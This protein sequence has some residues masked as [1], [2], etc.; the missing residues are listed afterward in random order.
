M[1]NLKKNLNLL[2]FLQKKVANLKT[3]ADLDVLMKDAQLKAWIKKDL[4]PRLLFFISCC[5]FKITSYKGIEI[6]SDKEYYGTILCNE[7]LFEATDISKKEVFLDAKNQKYKHYLHNIR[8][9]NNLSFTL[10]TLDQLVSQPIQ[11]PKAT[12]KVQIGILDQFGQPN[13]NCI[14]KNY[15]GQPYK[16]NED[17]GEL[18]AATAI[19]GDQLNNFDDGCGVFQTIL[20]V[21]AYENIS[22]KALANNIK[23]AIQDHPEIRI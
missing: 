3:D 21:V 18:V 10:P 14:V 6:E 11:M 19:M 1:A 17:H 13:E 23:K 8:P 2:S 15:L 12:N 4:L 22:E 9:N 20:A 7:H 16:T 5:Y